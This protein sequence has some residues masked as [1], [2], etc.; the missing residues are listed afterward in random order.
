MYGVPITNSLFISPIR[1]DKTP[2]CKLLYHSNGT[3]MYLDNRPGEFRGDCINFVRFLKGLSYKEALLDIYKTMS[4]NTHST[5]TKKD[6]S[7]I[8][9][10]EKATI[11][12]NFKDFTKEDLDYWGQY[13]I[14][15]DLLNKFNIKSVKECFIKNKDGEYFNCRKKNELCFAYLFPDNTVKVYFP[16]RDSYRF[17]SNTTSIQGLAQLKDNPEYVVITKSLKDVIVLHLLGIPALAPQTESIIPSSIIDSFEKSYLFYDN[18]VAGRKASIKVRNKYTEVPILL[19]PQEYGV[20]D[21][22]DFIKKYGIDKTKQLIE[23]GRR[24]ISNL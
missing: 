18:D 19:I 9:N 5:Y 4:V 3:L 22:S 17:V 7:L 20:K 23:Y 24:R 12:L 6:I 11:K 15:I 13:Y 1:K 21:I 10:K 8:S 14:N 16:D 2:T